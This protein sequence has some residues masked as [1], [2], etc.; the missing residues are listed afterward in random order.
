[1]MRVG[2]L[3]WF[4]LAGC[5]LVFPLRAPDARSDGDPDAA[6]G[7]DAFEFRDAPFVDPGAPVVSS[8]LESPNPTFV[9]DQATLNISITGVPDRDVNLDLSG[10]GAFSTSSTVVN[11]G[12]SGT[13]AVLPITWAP[14]GRFEAVLLTARVAYLATPTV[15]NSTPIQATVEQRFGHPEITASPT[16]DLAAN[17]IIAFFVNL[18]PGPPGNA[19]AFGFTGSGGKARVALYAPDINNRPGA[20]VAQSP[21]FLLP[22][23]PARVEIPIA[24]P[25][26]IAGK[27]WVAIQIETQATIQVVGVDD[28]PVAFKSNSKFSSGFP[29]DFPMTTVTV[30]DHHRWAMYINVAP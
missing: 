13:V 20:L 7:L 10:P 8:F 3:A 14:P 15:A 25:V 2:L 16:A 27:A 28:S 5:D 9:G 19:V 1:M 29:P 6:L 22:A 11:L 21:A 17:D 4:A 18:G 26:S 12:G 24:M 23:I 30:V